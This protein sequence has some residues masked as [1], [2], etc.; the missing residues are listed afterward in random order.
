MEHGTHEVN[1]H[2][3]YDNLKMKDKMLTHDYESRQVFRVLTNLPLE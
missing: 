1:T 2:V 3:H